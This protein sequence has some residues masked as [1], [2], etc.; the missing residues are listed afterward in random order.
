MILTSKIY[1]ISF[2]IVT[3]C[4][5]YVVDAQE[6]KYRGWKLPVPFIAQDREKQYDC[7]AACCAM[8]VQYYTGINKYESIWGVVGKDMGIQCKLN[9]LSIPYLPHP[10]S[11]LCN[12][13]VY[14]IR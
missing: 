4:I 11:I 12:E 9:F 13:K 10:Q 5:Q 14:L 7:W 6:D 1:I 3:L 8:V 2:I